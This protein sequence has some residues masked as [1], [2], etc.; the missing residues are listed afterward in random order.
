MI[1]ILTFL[2]RKLRRLQH[3]EQKPLSLQQLTTKTKLKQLYCKLPVVHS[4]N[5]ADVKVKVD[6]KLETNWFSS[7]Q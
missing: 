3:I 7:E 5:D 1:L 6:T 2:F 4:G